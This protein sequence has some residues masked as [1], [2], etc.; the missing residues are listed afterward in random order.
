MEARREFALFL[1][2]RILVELR[3][4]ARPQRMVATL[5]IEVANG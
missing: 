2:S 4:A 3:R 5:Q 1:A